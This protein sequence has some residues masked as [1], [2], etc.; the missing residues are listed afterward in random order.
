MHFDPGKLIQQ[1]QSLGLSQ[2]TLATLSNVSVRTIQRAESGEALRRENMA[3]IAAA[4]RMQINALLA[5][6]D[7]A[8]LTGEGELVTLRRAGSGREILDLLESS[9]LAKLEC[10]AD[11]T[12]E[13]MPALRE[14]AEAIEPWLPNPW[15]DR[16]T[17]PSLVARLEAVARIDRALLRLAEAGLALFVGRRF[18]QA[19]MPRAY[20]EGYD[21]P[22]R[23]RPEP[24]AAARLLVA[25]AERERR[26]VDAVTPW[27][28]E[29]ISGSPG[30]PD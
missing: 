15:E 11:P 25:G 8:E 10:E 28:V 3:D 2:E 4:L 12:A 21:I 17:F 6:A 29:V 19:V 20:D 9:R 16:R 26:S 7:E 14:T 13:A 1:R 27:P 18:E 5:S 22:R 24:V 30:E 23:A